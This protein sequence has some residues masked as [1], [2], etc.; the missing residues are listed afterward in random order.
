MF[1]GTPHT[2]M[3]DAALRAKGNQLPSAALS[4]L[5]NA[6][7]KGSPTLQDIN[8]QFAP[9]TKWFSIYLLWEQLESKFGNTQGY[10]VAQDSADPGWDKADRAGIHA[11]HSQ[12]CKFISETDDGFKIVL[13]ACLR[14]IE[15]APQVIQSRREKD[16]DRLKQENKQAAAELRRYDSGLSVSGGPSPVRNVHFLVPRSSSSLFTG[17]TEA[18]DL[19]RQRIVST[20]LE[21]GDH[22]HKIYVIWGLGGSG[23]TQFC[24]KFVEDNRDRYVEKLRPQPFCG[25]PNYRRTFLSVADD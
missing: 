16:R 21:R 3:S 7:A 23:K 6:L 11:D 9:L 10:I 18:A 25:I 8:D 22:Q 19:L 20:P 1:F 17:R 2:G 5:S 15:E 24:L 12:M 14:Y 4:Q 13:S